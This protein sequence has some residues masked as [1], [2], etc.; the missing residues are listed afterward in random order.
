MIL[1]IDD[2]LKATGGR[3]LA[4]T[5]AIA[6]Q[7]VMT[8][9]RALRPGD[10]YVPLK[11]PRFDGHDF[12]AE[13]A[14]LGAAGLLVSRDD[15]D[16]PTGLCALRV[17]DTLAAYGDIARFWRER[18]GLKVIAVTGSS[19]KT[20]TKELIA[21]LLSRYMRVG[22]THANHNNEI[23]VPKTLLGMEAEDDACILE[24][25][26]RG[27]GEIAYLASVARPTIGLITNIGTAHIGRLGTQEAIAKAKGE[28]L[29]VGGPSMTALLN[30]DDPMI[31]AQG[32]DHPGLTVTYSLYDSNATL[33]AEGE[34]KTFTI[35]WQANDHMP[36]GKTL[37]TL[38]LAG[39][40]HRTNAMAAFSVAWA[41][42]CALPKTLTLSPEALP[43]RARVLQAGGIDFIDE[44]YN[45]NPESVRATLS[46]FLSEPC[47][48]RQVAVLA[49]MGELG[50]YAEVAHRGIG[51][52]VAES[53]ITRFFA[54][55]TLA[56]WMAEQA[57]SK[58]VHLDDNAMAIEALKAYL[59][60]GDRVFIKGSRST[61]LE[62][63]VNALLL[64]FGGTAS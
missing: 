14:R 27:P 53:T 38:P 60:P 3:L 64:Y 5:G 44:T 35:H 58:T 45:A 36:A 6:F 15:L 43:G 1:T 19:G 51:T 16:L 7:R 25:G 37:L 18:L 52:M 30:M 47:E 10:L 32:Q 33:W 12:L 42:G 63:I 48:G 34:G 29:R 13:A 41:L 17:E 23:G 28:L 22:K 2:L 24:M 46:G 11:G 8:D 21:S 40:H 59:Q 55:G 54:V 49:E 26:M 39:Q 20:S 57:S 62:E 56:K 4:G 31:M 50:T 61:H 9:T